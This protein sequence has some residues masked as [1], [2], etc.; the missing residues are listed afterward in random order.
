MSKFLLVASTTLFTLIF[1]LSNN[2]A[3]MKFWFDYR[4][5][6][7]SLFPSDKYTY[8][9]FY[10]I[11]YLKKYKDI[12]VHAEDLRSYH[13][14]SKRSTNVNLYSIGDSY[15]AFF[16][17]SDSLL[18]NAD[19][20]HFVRYEYT[21]KNIYLDRSKKNIL[22]IEMV[23]REIRPRLLNPSYI[24]NHLSIARQPS[25]EKETDYFPNHCKNNLFN[26][27]IEQNL[28]FNLF[29]YAIFQPFRELK[30][31]LNYKMFDRTSSSVYISERKDRLYFNSTID[32]TN[33]QSSFTTIPNPEIDLMVTNLNRIRKHYLKLGFTEVYLSLIPNPVTI[34]EPYLFTYNKLIPR[35]Q[36]HPELAVPVINTYSK[37][38]K[39][40]DQPI[41]QRSD[42]HWDKAGFLAWR[43][44]MDSVLATHVTHQ[45]V[46]RPSKPF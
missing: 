4:V 10:G 9:D 35:L 14:K 11:T 28:T 24:Y 8:A 44:Q 1:I 39:I 16:I 46:L 38:H 42:S 20:Y 45:Y 36:S 26:N 5:S 18:K 6:K 37:L 43:D 32:T 33:S 21:S 12:A 31:E 17:K 41:F 7:R 34:L 25:D 29:D 27:K 22:V 23:E 3:F 19:A 30:A 13:Y 2:V 15:L 40:A